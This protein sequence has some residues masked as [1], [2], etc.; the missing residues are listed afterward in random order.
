M[1]IDITCFDIK[2]VP[3]DPE[4][5]FTFPEGL[6]G[7]EEHKRF[8]FLNEENRRTVF[9]LQSLDQQ[10]I[11]FPVVSPET[12]DMSYQIELSDEDLALIGLEK[13]EDATVAVIVY[14]NAVPSPDP[15]SSPGISA[16]TR[17]PLILNLKKRI[18]MQKVL[19]EVHPTLL[20]RAR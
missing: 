12:L 19:R 9:W 13:P 20:Y 8:I 7:F 14:R 6:V 16:N 3:I 1:K 2:D 4:A 11:M 18:G 5:V 15:E 17:S 10:E